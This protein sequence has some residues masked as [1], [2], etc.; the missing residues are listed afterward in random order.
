MIV[1]P[2]HIVLGGGGMKCLS[3]VGA[4]QELDKMNLLKHI[5]HFHGVSAGAFMFCICFRIFIK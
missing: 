2:T 5:K 4:F 3:Y 1:P